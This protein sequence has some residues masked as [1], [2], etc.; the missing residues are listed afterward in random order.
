MFPLNPYILGSSVSGEFKPTDI[1]DCVLWLRSDLGVTKDESDLVSSWTDQSG[2][3][4]DAIQE[5]G[6][7]QPLFK[8]SHLNEKPVIYFDGLNDYFLANGLATK[9]YFSGNDKPMTAFI[10]SKFEGDL[11]TTG[12]WAL[13]SIASDNVNGANWHIFYLG[14]YAA[15]WISDR[16]DNTFAEKKLSPNWLGGNGVNDP[17]LHTLKFS[18]TALTYRTDGDVNTTD[19]DLNVGTAALDD[20]FAIGALYEGL[21]SWISSYW[22]GDIAEIIIY[23]SV[24][25]DALISTVEQYL[26][27]RYNLHIFPAANYVDPT[28]IPGCLGWYRANLGITK[29][30]SNKVSIWADQS[31]NGHHANQ[32]TGAN[33]P[34]WQ[35]AQINGHPSIQFDG[36][37]Y[38]MSC[39][40]LANHLA[41]N[42]I[43]HSV[44]VV[45]RSVDGSYFMENFLGF[46]DSAGTGKVVY[47]SLFGSGV[48][49]TSRVDDTGASANQGGAIATGNAWK[50]YEFLFK[51]NTLSTINLN[52]VLED[53]RTRNVGTITL[54]TGYIGREEGNT[55]WA[56]KIAEI[57][58]YDHVLSTT[59]LTALRN[60]LNAEYIMY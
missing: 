11:E 23:K 44:V 47:G 10:V 33:Q 39:D 59:E 54:D 58:V 25:S 9:E 29:D 2:N 45:A 17:A 55:F 7:S 24:L 21:G 40:G 35:D 12:N 27:D 53:S 19:G 3:S 5:N 41:G 52:T 56:G 14:N 50:L 22:K 42:D 18:G 46:A 6:I 4:N 20:S 49:Q 30:G 48:L 60:A 16:W 34:L 8:D 1:A 36:L 13:L 32:E 26:S 57:I 37:A 15:T 31:G 43:P 28:S 38:F 51:S